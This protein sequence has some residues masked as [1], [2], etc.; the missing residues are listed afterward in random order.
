[1]ATTTTRTKNLKL[2]VSDNLTAEA[3]ANLYAIDRFAEFLVELS[4]RHIYVG[5][6]SEEIVEVDTT[7]L[8]DVEASES[9]GLSLKS[10]R[11]TAFTSTSASTTLSLTADKKGR[12]TSIEAKPIAITSGQITD[13]L[14]AVDAITG[15]DFID[16]APTFVPETKGQIVIDKLSN[17]PVLYVS[18]DKTGPSDWVQ[19]R[20][21][22][23]AVKRKFIIT[24]QDILNGYLTL[25]SSEIIRSSVVA[26]FDRLP[27]FEGAD[28]DYEIFIAQNGDVRLIFGPN[29]RDSQ[30][31]GEVF[32]ISY[33][34]P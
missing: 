21:A 7:K 8:G 32:R 29:L 10:V 4:P 34:T 33:W 27:L 18:K 17:P 1:M 22:P 11:E 5:N 14:A 16:G 19:F 23:T 9:S 3:K 26:F 2:F 24:N 31:V 13:F 6:D 25:T 20:P 28:E 12:V 15:A 30:Y